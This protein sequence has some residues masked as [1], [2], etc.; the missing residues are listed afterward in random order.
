MAIRFLMIRR[1]RIGFDVF[2]G[3]PLHHLMRLIIR[4]TMSDG[5]IKE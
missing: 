4:I 5:D 2:E 1:L 3:N